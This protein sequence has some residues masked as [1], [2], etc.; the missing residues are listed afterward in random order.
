M[1]LNMNMLGFNPENIRFL[2]EGI[3]ELRG[4]SIC[5]FYLNLC[6]NKMKSKFDNL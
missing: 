3:R 1:D 2:S 4:S 5:K 6:D